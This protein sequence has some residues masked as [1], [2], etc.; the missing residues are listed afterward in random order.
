[1]SDDDKRIIEELHCDPE[2][3]KLLGYIEAIAE[4]QKDLSAMDGKRL[5]NPMEFISELD[6]KVLKVADYIIVKYP[7]TKGMIQN[8]I[9]FRNRQN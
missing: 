7:E 3:T 5:I 1:M 8:A 4:I 9:L 6:V 2:F